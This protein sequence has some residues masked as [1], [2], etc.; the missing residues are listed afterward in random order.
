M[1]EIY[2]MSLRSRI[3][4]IEKTLNDSNQVWAYFKINYYMDKSEKELAQQRLINEYLA[5][6]LPKPHY[7]IFINESPGCSKTIEK[8]CFLKSEIINF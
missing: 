5:Q 7:S 8:E 2:F 6:G 3:K 4:K 1:V